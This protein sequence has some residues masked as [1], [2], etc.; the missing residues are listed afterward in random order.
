MMDLAGQFSALVVDFRGTPEFCRVA[1]RVNNLP[2]GDNPWV[3][4]AEIVAAGVI[5][6]LLFFRKKFGYNT[7]KI[8]LQRVELHLSGK[9]TPAE[10]HV[11]SGHPAQ[12]LI[13]R[14][15]K[16]PPEELFEIEELEIYELLPSLHTTV[17]AFHPEKRGRFPMI[18][19]GERK[20]G[21]IVVD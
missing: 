15:D 10:V 4:L 3:L 19:G 8:G 12:L 7:E 21:I 2:N 9:L 20:A 6:Y 5:L 11:T 16:D 14:F 18:L 13:H 17:I 1:A